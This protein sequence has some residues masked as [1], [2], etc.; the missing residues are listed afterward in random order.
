M[1][2]RIC[3]WDF[4]DKALARALRTVL[5]G[6]VGS[7]TTC[8]MLQEI[9]WMAIGSGAAVA[10]LISLANSVIAGLPEADKEP[11]TDGIA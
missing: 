5:Q 2:K 7:A 4:W 10:V 3:T 6:F 11:N 9:N 1:L 8:V